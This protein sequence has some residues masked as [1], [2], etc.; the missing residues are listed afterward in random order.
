MYSSIGHHAGLIKITPVE[1]QKL[2]KGA[3]GVWVGMATEKNKARCRRGAKR[4]GSG[5]CRFVVT[6]KER[7]GKKI[8]LGGEN[9][10]KETQ[11]SRKEK[12][13]NRV[14]PV[15]PSHPRLPSAS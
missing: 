12:V 9:S 15:E 7:E 2:P 8:A 3:G 6:D 11:D 10:N 1:Q 5:T 14:L 13:Q 4:S